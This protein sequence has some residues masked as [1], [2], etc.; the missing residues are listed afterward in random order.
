MKYVNKI[1]QLQKQNT[2]V[3]PDCAEITIVNTDTV[4]VARVNGFPIPA[5]YGFISFDGKAG[6]KDVSNYN[7]ESV[8][9][10]KIFVILKQYV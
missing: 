5:N 10:G 2:Q 1:F 6:E 8:D 9:P 3:T 4:N 7:I